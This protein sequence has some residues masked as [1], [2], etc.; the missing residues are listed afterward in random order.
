MDLIPAF[1]SL[2]AGAGVAYI[3]LSRRFG[4]QI[5]VLQAASDEN[6]IRHEMAVGQLAKAESER[7]RIQQEADRAKGDGIRLAAEAAHL[8]DK[9]DT[10]KR[11]LEDL[12][13]KVKAEF[14]VLAQAILDE[15]SAKFTEQN[16]ANL[17]Q[18]LSPLRENLDKFEKQVREAY[19]VENREKA[20]LK[21]EIMALTEMN[22]RMS[23]DAL[24]LVK[25]LKGDNKAAGNWGEMILERLLEQAGLQEGLNYT[26]QGSFRDEGGQRLMPDVVIRLPNNKHIVVDSKVSLLS[27]SDW[28]AADDDIARER[29]AKAFVTSV[30][31]HVRGLSD[32]N[33]AALY[34]IQSPDF[35]LLFMPIEP[36][37]A[38]ALRA[39]PHLYQNAYDRNI[40]LVSPTTLMATLTTVA[41]LWRQEQG[42]RNAEKIAVEA[43][44]LYD[45]L[46][47]FVD[48]FEKIGKQMDT[49]R[50]S[51]EG[52]ENKLLSGTGA[53]VRRAEAM[54]RLGAKTSKSLPTLGNDDEADA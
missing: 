34:G 3:L 11:D 26:A 51:Y 14:T 4:A 16:K 15:K 27:Y 53:V 50:K 22:Q 35:V 45:K 36:A 2:I 52:A 10:Q 54:K 19:D 47:G 39:D 23:D 48:D 9:L 17:D 6:R 43:G 25:A 7:D 40:I 5:R 38:L 28:V 30:W 44:K 31:T 18:V 29:A 33:Y 20:S 41:N 13:A 46:A 49:L 24:N 32:K 8:R 12:Q 42:I 37:F 21:T 1:L